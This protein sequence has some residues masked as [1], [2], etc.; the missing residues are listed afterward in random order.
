MQIVESQRQETILNQQKR[1]IIYCAK[2]IL[3]KINN[4]L[5]LET[6]KATKHMDQ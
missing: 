4:W 2:V 3:G 1:K 6:M 5:S